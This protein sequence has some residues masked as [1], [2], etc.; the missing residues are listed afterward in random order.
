MITREL[1]NRKVSPWWGVAFL[2]VVIALSARR[3]LYI[4]DPLAKYD[5]LYRGLI[6]LGLIVVVL[7]VLLVRRHTMRQR[8]AIYYGVLLPAAMFLLVLVSH[9]HWLLRHYFQSSPVRVAPD[10]FLLQSTGYSCSPTAMANLMRLYGVPSTEGEMAMA[11]E[12]Q[13]TGSGQEEI[14]R[15]FASQGWEYYD[16]MTTFPELLANN[17]PCL[18]T[19]RLPEYHMILHSCALLA[20]TDTLVQFADPLRGL[21]AFTPEHFIS[22]WTGEVTFAAPPGAPILYDFRQPFNLKKVATWLK[23]EPT[24]L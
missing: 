17:R 4:A 21:R 24:L 8:L 3:Y 16:T 9:S 23:P 13:L 12:M 7:S 10:G 22:V 18:V 6:A 11:M 5:L 2:A 14:A 19:V 15:G 1:L 20:I